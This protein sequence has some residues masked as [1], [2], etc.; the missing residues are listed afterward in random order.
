MDSRLHWIWLQQA[1]GYGSPLAAPLLSHFIDPAAVYAADE[2]ALRQFDLPRAVRARLC[3]KSCDE[4]RGILWRTLSDGDWLLTPADDAYPALLRGIPSAPLVLY[5]RGIL[6]DFSRQPTVA[7]VGTRCLTNYGRRMAQEMGR[8]L[9][10]GRA[11]VVSGCAEGGDETVLNAAMEADGAVVSVLPAGL[12]VNAP[13]STAAL[14]RRVLERDGALITEYPYGERVTRGTF[15]VR[16]RLI[17]GLSLGVCV[18]E[19]PAR[20]GTLITAAHAREQGRDV[21][22][23]PGDVTSPASA[24]TNA[25]I[26]SGAKLVR[27]AADILEEYTPLF[28]HILHREEPDVSAPERPAASAAPALPPSASA[29]AKAVYAVLSEVPR[30]ADEIAALADVPMAVVFA[31]LT[32]L[33]LFGCAV[34]AAGRQ[35][36]RA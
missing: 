33:E 2:K 34:S 26:Q 6:P 10:R 12:D 35:Y 13:A 17:S 28:P 15:H 1:L 18:I 7:V 20:S 8:G 19:A 3:D 36:S 16:N 24:G 9:A 14:R 29:D 21:F 11:I 5:G 23:L 32:E 25:L 30:P 22:A 27:S 4:A 31:A